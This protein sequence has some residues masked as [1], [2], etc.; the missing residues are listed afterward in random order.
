MSRYPRGWAFPS[1]EQINDSYNN[2]QDLSFHDQLEYIS[3]IFFNEHI[4]LDY[5]QFEYEINH[6]ITYEFT[7]YIKE[8]IPEINIVNLNFDI[9]EYTKDIIIFITY[10]DESQMDYISFEKSIGSEY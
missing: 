1:K 5:D 2:N 9:S 7:N 8:K 10:F 4:T 3:D 6:E